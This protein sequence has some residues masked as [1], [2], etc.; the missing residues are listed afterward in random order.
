[1]T[2]H[3]FQGVPLAFLWRLF[4]WIVALTSFRYVWNAIISSWPTFS[5]G[6]IS[7][8]ASRSESMQRR[9]YWQVGAILTGESMP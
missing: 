3:G 7:F 5:V 8:T 2:Q 1:M 6:M 4:F 9:T